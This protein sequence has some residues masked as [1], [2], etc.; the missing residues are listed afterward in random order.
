[1]AKATCPFCGQYISTQD[2]TKTFK[3]KKYH[4]QC[5]GKILDDME[6][7]S[8]ETEELHKYICKILEIPTVT[9][10]VFV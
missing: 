4:L 10:Y 8:N 1:M 9:P 2:E 3:G 5:F 6:S 7:G